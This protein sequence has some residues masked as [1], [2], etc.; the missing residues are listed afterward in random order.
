MTALLEVQDLHKH[1][2]GVQA[3]TACSFTAAEGQ[4]TGLIGPNGA[5]KSTAIDLISGFK[6]PDTGTVLFEGKP[7]AGQGA[8]P[9]LADGP[10]S[11]L[12]EPARVAG[13]QRAREPHPRLFRAVAA[14]GSGDRCGARR[15]P[16]RSTPTSS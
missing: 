14:S 7:G 13:S 11:D 1:F 9:H 3:V 16:R 12:S 4:I 2:G 15:A 8:A 6:I 5:G 10:D